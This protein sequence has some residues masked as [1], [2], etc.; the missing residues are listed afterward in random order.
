[1][2]AP[3]V[4]Y[5]GGWGEEDEEG[6]IDSYQ[7]T[8]SEALVVAGSGTDAKASPSSLHKRS[9]ELGDD[10]VVIGPVYPASRVDRTPPPRFEGHDTMNASLESPMLQSQKIPGRK[11][12]M[13][14]AERCGSPDETSRQSSVP[15]SSYSHVFHGH[16]SSPSVQIINPSPMVHE[17]FGIPTVLNESQRH[18]PPPLDAVY[19]HESSTRQFCS[20]SSPI[21]SAR[22]FPGPM[23]SQSLPPVGGSPKLKII[24]T[25][26][27][28]KSRK[29][30]EQ[31]RR[32]LNEDSPRARSNTE[33]PVRS[34]LD[35]HRPP[36]SV[37][38]LST[39]SSVTFSASVNSSDEI[40]PQ[41]SPSHLEASQ[42]SSDPTE[43]IGVSSLY[44][45]YWQD[46][47]DFPGRPSLPFQ[48]KT[49]LRGATNE[50][51]A[52]L[53]SS[54]ETELS[55]KLPLTEPS[56]TLE[57]AT[58]PATP[59]SGM[60]EELLEMFFV[61]RR[62][63]G[64]RGTM[65]SVASVEDKVE[66]SKQLSPI[67]DT[68]KRISLS[69]ASS[70]ESDCLKVTPRTKELGPDSEGIE[71]LTGPTVERKPKIA[72]DPHNY[73]ESD[74]TKELLSQF[75]RPQ[76]LM[77][78]ETIHIPSGTLIMPPML[79]MP[80]MPRGSDEQAIPEIVNFDKEDV[81]GVRVTNP[82]DALLK[83][84]FPS[85]PLLLSPISSDYHHLHPRGVRTN[86]TIRQKEIFQ[87]TRAIASIP[88]RVE[89]TKAYDSL[90]AH[91][92]ESSNFLSEWIAYQ[93]EH[94]KG[95]ELLQTEIVAIKPDLSL[96]N[97]KSRI[98]LVQ[99]FGRSGEQQS[100][101]NI[102]AVNRT[103]EKFGKMG[104]DAIRLGEKAG[105]KVVDWMKR[106]GKKVQCSFRFI[107]PINPWRILTRRTGT[108][109]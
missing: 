49:S 86:R 61:G 76:T 13:E 48:Q 93:M 69:L 20:Q 11:H 41:L 54:P 53:Q 106:A 83:G 78:K 100:D 56:N 21:D 28:H 16:V 96:R 84:V 3:K 108:Y 23:T 55:K 38:A 58:D 102:G 25:P 94:E 27:M 1:V 34:P 60:D 9:F 17:P 18:V 2:E 10:T 65:H 36:G 32:R 14:T 4:D 44:D 43:S 99:L 91:L 72:E 46:D 68:N 26:D 33:C 47:K 40:Y 104:R 98:G 50:K 51:Q 82:G 42:S 92:Q 97:G 7:P 6:A 22:Q 75:S 95:E 52:G 70:L 31:R 101:G 74:Y 5:G 66:K 87:D 12:I 64:R 67:I 57:S 63:L 8:L 29:E 30:A 62:F 35:V 24:R 77:L 79:P 103:E 15:A 88:N 71:V 90:R 109:K 59:T 89:R 81:E 37:E 73:V 80:P 19:V 105:G 85:S 107:R 39:Q 45:S